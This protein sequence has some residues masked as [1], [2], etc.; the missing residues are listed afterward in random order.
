MGV[1]AKSQAVDMNFESTGSVLV[2]DDNEMNR[3]MLVRR[4]QPLGYQVSVARDGGEALD[5]LMQQPFDLVLLD[6]M[7]PVKDG[8]E[9]LQEMKDHNELSMIPVIMITALDDTSSAARCIQLGA[10]DYLTKPFDPIL[11]KARVSTCMERKRLSDQERHYRIKI[12]EYNDE[13]QD[14]VQQQVQQITSAQLG[15][16]FAM[17]KLAESRDPE[18]GEHLERMREY[19]KV[20]SVQLS[21]SPKYQSLIDAEFID[22][23]YAASPLHDI[24]K[25]GIIDS[26]L[27]KPGQLTAEE[28]NIMKT[29]P[30]IGAATL[31]EVDRQHPG[32]SLIRMGIDIAE[33]HHERWD[34]TGYPYG[35]KGAEIPIVARIL[36]LGDVYDALT[37]KRC[38]KD[39]FDH[40]KSRTILQ[41][42]VGTHFDPEVV[43]AFL[44]TED[45]FQR[46]REFYQ[47]T[48]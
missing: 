46:I 38:Y 40:H 16:I 17:S 4:L 28:W 36:A 13:L 22:N 41:E 23:I 8:F 42:S 5:I 6:I 37:S 14:Q 25:V 7:M 15:A 29:H 30:I 27:L 48:E 31:R 19:C 11:L 35:L 45:E 32:N 18:T 3:D 44:A 10:E 43:D 21:R 9:V 1:V 12:E 20:L 24:G 33:S 2:V 26:V 34:G 39:A 47:D